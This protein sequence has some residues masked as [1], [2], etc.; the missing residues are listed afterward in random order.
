MQFQPIK[1]GDIS[2]SEK[3]FPNNLE[4]RLESA[5]NVVNTELK[6]ITLLHLNNIPADS[7]EIKE[8]VRRTIGKGYLPNG[9][10]FGAYGR[11]LHKISRVA[12]E[13]VVRDA[14]ETVYVGYSLT[15]AGKRYGQPIAELFLKWAVDNNIS[16]FSV[17]GSTLS[18]G[19]TRAPYNRVRILEALS[20]GEK[21]EIELARLLRLNPVTIS[22]N[23]V[24]LS[25][26]GFINFD[27]I[28]AMSRGHSR[29]IWIR[30]ANPENVGPI[31]TYPTLT[32]RIVE[33]MARG[34]E[35]DCNYLATELKCSVTHASSVLSGLERRGALRRTTPWVTGK[36]RSE[37]E[38]LDLGKGF[39]EEIVQ[40]IRTHLSDSYVLTISVDSDI[41]YY[42][43]QGI[44]IYRRVSPLINKKRCN[45]RIE[46]LRS[47]LA[48]NPNATTSE[49][50]EAT[51]QSRSSVSI[52][53]KML[54]KGVKTKKV[55]H[56]VRYSLSNL[57]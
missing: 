28:G 56:E 49:I 48:R 13:T 10:T 29:Y 9:N 50:A 57:N 47:Y 24:A 39:L 30:G 40:P 1:E 5:L 25:R 46:D 54:G 33:L 2:V 3:P 20:S 34:N 11:T 8:R 32:R 14:D 26:I 35:R 53:I 19:K 22:K 31:K 7:S 41:S 45:N 36:H 4:G 44:E 37:A 42:E 27:S 15:K 17:L 43:K 55:G 52:Y 12:K 21:N 6:A 38:L 18:G 51:G 16:M 23:L